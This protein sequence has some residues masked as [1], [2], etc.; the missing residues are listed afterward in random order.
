MNDDKPYIEEWHLKSELNIRKV[1]DVL[2]AK[3]HWFALSVFICLMLAFVYIRTVPV[4]YK[5]EAVVQLKNTAKSEE[6]FNEKQL[7]EDGNN[8]D[9]EIL[10]FKSRLL[11]GE[12]IRRFGYHLFCG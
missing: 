6:A 4:V 5:R 1:W 10:I 9:G 12:V 11:M 8:I 2:L 3:W 7:F